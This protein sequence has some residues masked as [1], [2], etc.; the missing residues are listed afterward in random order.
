MLSKVSHSASQGPKHAFR[1]NRRGLTRFVLEDPN[2][3]PD[4]VFPVNGFRGVTREQLRITAP[5]FAFPSFA[6]C[7]NS[8]STETG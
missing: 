7:F 3:A 8:F 4:R 6:L 2:T 5:F 1:Q